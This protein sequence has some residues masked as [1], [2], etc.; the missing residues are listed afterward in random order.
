VPDPSVPDLEARVASSRNGEDATAH[1]DALNDLAWALRTAELDRA[2]ALAT[3]ARELA[4]EHDY[5][6]GQARATRTLAMAIRNPD[7]LSSVFQLGEEAMRL[8]DEAGDAPGR[9]GARDFL[10]SIHEHVGDLARGLDFALDALSIAREIDD[11]IRQGYALSS[12][13]GILAAS[14]ET[15]AAI[16]RLEEALDLFET[17]GDLQGVG[18]ICSRLAKVL[19]E[20]GRDDDALAFADK[21]R[22]AA[23]ATNNEYLQSS[24]LQSMAALE[25]RR[26]HAEE[27]ERLYRAAI[28]ALSI[29][30]ARA[31][32]GAE[33]RVSLARLLIAQG[34]LDEAERELTITLSPLEDDVSIV[35]Q[36]DAHET[37]AG[38][39]ERQGKLAD[40]IA[41]LR[42]AH[43]LRERIH[44]QE[45]R[46][47]LAQLEARVAMETATKDA[48][49]HKL[50][51][52]EL[53]G[54]QAKLVEAEK[55]AL[56]G[57]LAAGTAHE[58][59]TPLGVL[60][61]NAKLA[62]TATEQLLSLAKGDDE[63]SARAKRLAEVLATC[64]QANEQSLARIAAVAHGFGRFAELDQ[65]AR[66]AF[67]V[68]N[69]LDSAVALLSPTMPPGVEL[70]HHHTDTPPVEGWPR[71]INHAFMTV[72]Q[73]AADAID[74]EGS[75]TTE[76]GIEDDFVV[77]RIR[78]TGR[79][80]GEQEVSRLFDVSWNDE[81]DRV[82][83]RLGLS[84]AYA[85]MQKH[86]GSLDVEST[87]GSGTTVTFRF[88][89]PAD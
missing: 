16:E 2:H 59:H 31:I 5:V 51:F 6:L 25:E 35:A 80:M 76:L 53:H 60:R 82:K 38:L 61:S 42:K 86:G 73:N 85:T 11:P 64:R 21:C 24:A 27:A 69:S 32:V 43:V 44:D 78:D 70:R 13:G 48:E 4:R 88:P 50:R 89:L 1:I 14:G 58:L 75:I 68:S 39:R 3:E 65:T 79:G 54:M 33:I 57:R 9:A 10:A 20:T 56:L 47:K 45:A 49:I 22:D 77:V 8:F 67:A 46:N 28:D 37:M 71:E 87:L 72:L 84:A 63:L 19:T 81:G 52:V 83:M 30:S 34:T 74:G 29:P 26:G 15:D 40:A 55:M 17:A 41:H 66:R 12:V 62:A 18:T 7:E 36:T 23:E